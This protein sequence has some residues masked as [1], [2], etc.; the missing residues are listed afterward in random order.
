MKASDIEDILLHAPIEFT[1]PLKDK[2][3]KYHHINRHFLYVHFKDTKIKAVFKPCSNKRINSEILAYS[4]SHSLSLNIIPPTVP[5]TIDTIP[6]VLQLYI[7]GSTDVSFEALNPDQQN[8]LQFTYFL[9]GI[10][11]STPRNRILSETKQL[12]VIDNESMHRWY[13]IQP[14]QFPFVCEYNLN[15]PHHNLTLDELKAFPFHQVRSLDKHIFQ[16]EKDF[17]LNYISSSRFTQQQHKIEDQI[18]PNGQ[19]EC[20]VYLEHLWLKRNDQDFLRPNPT[21]TDFFLECI[22]KLPQLLEDPKVPPDNQHII[23]RLI[24]RSLKLKQSWSTNG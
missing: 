18:Y 5:R 22:E 15:S 20:V 16:E 23:E 19:L 2:L 11:D 12:Y 4:I 1:E 10:N 9:L 7:E 14:G 24:A 3:N 6:G 21:K 13:A 8:L 17:F